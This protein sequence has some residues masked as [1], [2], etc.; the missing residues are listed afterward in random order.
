MS[1]KPSTV[2]F[3][4]LLIWPIL[5]TPFAQVGLLNLF[6]FC[7]IPL[8][9]GCLRTSH[10]SDI[11]I[12]TFFLFYF[13][14]FLFLVGQFAFGSDSALQSARFA[15]L[16]LLFY[17][18]YLFGSI[19]LQS[20]AAILGIVYAIK[21]FFVLNI[22]VIILAFSSS[23]F[24]IFFSYLYGQGDLYDISYLTA[25]RYFGF[26]GQPAISAHSAVFLFFLMNFLSQTLSI[27]SKVNLFSSS[28]FHKILSFLSS[29]GFI[30][31]IVATASRSS[32]IS[33]FFSWITL[34][35][36]RNLQ[37]NKPSCLP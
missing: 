11:V 27:T 6:L 36:D 7:L 37:I 20:R 32:I 21:A 12:P 18:G 8:I 2:Y 25:V 17:S 33:F 3:Y 28:F 29:V 23:Q 24:S 9:F 34:A 15:F 19:V 4:L 30:T 16:P 22:L 35:P 10:H 13:L 14:F 31:I 1:F 5:Y 26:S